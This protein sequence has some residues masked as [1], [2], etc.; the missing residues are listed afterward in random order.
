MLFCAT[1]T[2]QQQLT[3]MPEALADSKQRMLYVIDLKPQRFNRQLQSYF[4][5]P[6]ESLACITASDPE[7]Y[8]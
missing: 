5:P 8:N 7:N 1:V 4:T 2:R 6:G 3:L